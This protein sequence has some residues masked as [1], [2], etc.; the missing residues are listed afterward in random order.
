MHLRSTLCTQKYQ[1]QNVHFCR[2]RPGLVIEGQELKIG[3]KIKE[4]RGGGK[5]EENQGKNEGNQGK[6]EGI[7]QRK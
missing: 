6:Y 2:A 5:Y 3:E 4:I 7:S 1:A